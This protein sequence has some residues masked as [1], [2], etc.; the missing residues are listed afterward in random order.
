[1]F[2]SLFECNFAF[3]QTCFGRLSSIKWLLEM[4]LLTVKMIRKNQIK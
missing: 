4:V 3:L 1:M 2:E